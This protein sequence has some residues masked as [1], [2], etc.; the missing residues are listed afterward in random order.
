MTRVKLESIMA[1]RPKQPEF[2]RE[3]DRSCKLHI[4]GSSPRFGPDN[5]SVC[6]KNILATMAEIRGKNKVKMDM[7]VESVELI[8][9]ELYGS[10]LIYETLFKDGL[11]IKVFIEP[12]HHYRYEEEIYSIVSLRDGK[13]NGI[14]KN[15][16]ENGFLES[17]M[18]MEEDNTKF[19]YVFRMNRVKKLYQVGDNEDLKKTNNLTPEDIE[20]L[21]IN[22]PEVKIK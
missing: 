17:L 15:F 11:N 3:F 5:Y 7:N 13:F 21:R 10:R 12:S 18:M 6:V 2:A 16:D 14:A 1:D 4:S 20:F 19:E 9:G 8:I 22:A